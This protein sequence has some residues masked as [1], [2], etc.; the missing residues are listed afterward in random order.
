MWR[1]G[2]GPGRGEYAAQNTEGEQAQ[3]L[4]RA[5]QMGRS[6]GWVGPMFLWNLNFGPV[7]GAADEAAFGIVRPDWSPRPAYDALRDMGK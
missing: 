2:R 3:F 5:Y 6:W 1:P 4:V 7:A